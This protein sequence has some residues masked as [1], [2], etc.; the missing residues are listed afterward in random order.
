MTDETA[1]IDTAHA[2]V[3]AAAGLTP[4][5]ILGTHAKGIKQVVDLFGQAGLSRW[6]ALTVGKLFVD[7]SIVEG[8]AAVVVTRADDIGAV[9]REVAFLKSEQRVPAV[10]TIVTGD[11]GRLSVNDIARISA[12]QLITLPLPV[13]EFAQHIKT[14]MVAVQLGRGRRKSRL[15]FGRK[16][17]LLGELLVQNQVI[18]SQE[19]KKALDYQGTADLR[20]GDVLVLLGYISETQKTEFLASQL[21]V[22]T[23][24][25]RKYT[26]LDP[27]T[28]ALIPEHLAKRNTCIAIDKADGVLTVAMADVLN[29]A[30]LDT[31]RDLTNMAIKPV[32]GTAEDIKTATDR[33]YQA[34]ASQQD[35]TDFVADL[36]EQVEFV[37]HEVADINIEEAASAGEEVGIV[38]L[39]NLFIANAVRDRA[40]DIHIEPL[41]S[42]LTVRYRIDGELRSV[43]TAPRRSHPAILTRVKILSNLDIA[44]RRLPQDGRMVVKL[45]NREVDIRVSIL[46]TVFGEKAVLRILDRESF[47]KSVTNLG[48]TD[49]DLATFKKNITR[50]YGIIVVTGPTGSGKS[51]TLYSAMQHIKSVTSNIVTVED[52]VEFHME[53][54]NQVH[55]NPRIGL[56]FASALRAILRQDPDVVL[57]G[58]IRDAETADI[59]IKMALTGHLVFSSLHTNDAASTIAR[60]TDIGI[61]PL[62]LSSSLSLIVAQRLV[63]SVCLKCREEY[64]LPEEV[65]KKL[66][67]LPEDGRRFYR[68][69]GCVACNGSG[70]SGRSGIFEMIEITKEMRGL[71]I[72]NASP[73]ELEEQ[74]RR[75][76]MVCL[77]DAGIALAAQGVT[78]IEQVIAE[79]SDAW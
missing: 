47:Q 73:Q 22:Q 20:L 59:A 2:A 74:A 24:P 1:T 72:R 54:I 25:T 37:K 45:R 39:V 42:T 44:E 63:R 68:G 55:V 8:I 33:V 4:I 60:F 67:L 40:S 11:V 48:F 3:G 62:L 75:D 78:T 12:D 35:A 32:L 34:I 28:V 71:I 18:S 51:T 43:M 38:K 23:V 56:T 41:E 66:S 53:G 6:A 50:P 31:L 79:T 5:R 26:T 49:R 70:Y 76:G 27:G 9:A 52:P 17:N 10:I 61:P 64:E 29:L 36:G 15:D 14:R 65:V 58:E 16:Q 30:L 57:I 7:R 19:L 13:E 46:P 77:R 69:A 21:G